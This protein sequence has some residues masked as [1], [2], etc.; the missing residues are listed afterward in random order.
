MI[1]YTK[2]TNSKNMKK[3][4]AS[5]QI[6]KAFALALILLFVILFWQILT[7]S[8]AEIETN[9]IEF[10]SKYFDAKQIVKE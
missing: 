9:T 8:D 10:L 5:Q 7:V 2:K 1:A 6:I 3:P 4:T